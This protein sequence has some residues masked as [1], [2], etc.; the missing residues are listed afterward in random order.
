[1]VL[2]CRLVGGAAGYANIDPFKLFRGIL[3]IGIYIGPLHGYVHHGAINQDL[4]H[5]YT[6]TISE[7]ELALSWRTSLAIL[8]RIATYTYPRTW[9]PRLSSS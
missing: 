6:A 2:L 8:L 7:H 4:A 3:C 1:M 5:I 9:P